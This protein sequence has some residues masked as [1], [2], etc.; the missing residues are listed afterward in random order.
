VEGKRGK[1]RY[2]MALEPAFAVRSTKTSGAGSRGND[3]TEGSFWGL[4]V[5]GG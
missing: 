5:A 4:S 3:S 2:A 1:K